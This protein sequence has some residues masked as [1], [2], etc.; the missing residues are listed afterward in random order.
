MVKQ[1]FT[2]RNLSKMLKAKRLMLKHCGYS[3]ILL[4]FTKVSPSGG[5][6][7]GAPF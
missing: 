3:P 6:L 7:E 2:K 4:L 1:V 5:D